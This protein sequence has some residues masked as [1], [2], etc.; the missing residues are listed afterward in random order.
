MRMRTI[1]S[2]IKTDLILLSRN[3]I[4]LYMVLS[5]ALLAFVY[6]AVLG[7]INQE[8]LSLAVPSQLPAEVVK[9]LQRVARVEQLDG[10]QA[11]LRRVERMDSVAGVI[12]DQGAFTLVLEGNEPQGFAPQAQLLLQ[13]ALAEDIPQHQSLEIPS[14]GGRL[15][16]FMAASLLLLVIFMAGT[17]L[18]FNIVAERESRSIK[19]LAV[20]PLTLGRYLLA[21]T[22]SALL[23]AVANTAIVGLAIGR[24]D[25]VPQLLLAALA[26]AVLLGLLTAAFGYTADNQI[27][28]IASL[29]LLLPLV[30]ILPLSSMFL[31]DQLQWL[32]Y[33]L[34]N[35]WY[36]VA[37][38]QA[39]AGA[40]A[41]LALLALLATS[42]LWVLLLSRPIA[43][44]FGLKR[45]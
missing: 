18:G 37:F 31:S 38:R 24:A 30:L 20:T 39:W 15:A 5:P 12:W 21:R 35:Y 16:E 4:V 43:R 25:M 14:A 11:V 29:K 34:P 32:Y 27:T 23:L 7:G 33:W 45:R 2:I 6:M 19:A 44:R 3:V 40:A 42:L 22:A 9:R 13:R 28:A 26:A 17:V 36:L 10:E 8:T 1:L 41:P